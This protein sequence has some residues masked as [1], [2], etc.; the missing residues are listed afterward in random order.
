MNRLLL[1][2]IAAAAFVL[3]SAVFTRSSPRHPARGRTKLAKPYKKTTSVQ[4][5]SR[6]LTVAQVM[7]VVRGLREV[8]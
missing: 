7:K 2:P 6:H 4:L 1:V 3:S 8:G 5:S